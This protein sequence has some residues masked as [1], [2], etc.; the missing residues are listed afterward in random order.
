M[1]TK[2]EKATGEWGKLCNEE[3]NNLPSSQNQD[4]KTK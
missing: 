4:R 2:W 1:A 3:F